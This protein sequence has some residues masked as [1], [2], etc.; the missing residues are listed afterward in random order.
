MSI[1]SNYKHTIVACFIA[2]ISQAVIVNFLPLLFL[3]FSKQFN[4]GLDKITLLVSINFISQLITDVIATRL[5][6]VVGHRA[7]MLSAFVFAGVG[8]VSFVI[9]PELMP[10][11]LGLLISMVFCAIGSGLCEV[12]ISP[13]IEACPTVNKSAIMSLVHS[14]YCWGTVFVIATSTVFF[15]L[16]GTENWKTLILFWA[17][18]PVINALYFIFVPIYNTREEEQKAGGILKLF[19][20][21]QFWLFALLMTCA[22]V[23]EL[24]MGQWASVFAESALGVSKTLGD[25]IGPCTFA[26]LMGVSRT[27]YTVL[28]EKI[29]LRLYIIIS[30]ILAV[31]TYALASL[32]GSPLMS[33]VA[34]GLCGLAVGILWPGTLSLASSTIGAST[35]LFALYAVFGDLGATLGPTI[36]GVVSGA[37]N[38]DLKKGLACIIVFPIIIIIGLL[39]SKIKKNKKEK[40]TE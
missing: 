35:A 38:D 5:V 1:R 22:G 11:F 31:I 40:P 14:F 24:S 34:C 30:A 27:I 25:L 8:L 12:V 17:I 10:S 29:N 33:L 28:S 36:V 2:Y 39:L 32:S 18:I 3:T 26:L 21:W 4:I 16:F 6:N 13:I 9:L 15:V 37:F 23:T 20:K 7:C 19:G